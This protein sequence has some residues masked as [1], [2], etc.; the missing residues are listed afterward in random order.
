MKVWI[1]HELQ[2]TAEF[3]SIAYSHSVN[4]CKSRREEKSTTFYSGYNLRYF[5]SLKS[6]FMHNGNDS[7][8][9]FFPSYFM[10]KEFQHFFKK[11]KKNFNIKK[12][13]S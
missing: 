11:R 4:T 2:I 7:L 3:I 12:K 6:E 1:E 9:F 5:L 13:E 10:F 8:F